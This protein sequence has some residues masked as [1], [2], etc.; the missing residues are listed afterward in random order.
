MGGAYPAAVADLQAGGL[1]YV[2]AN[3]RDKWPLKAGWLKR[4]ASPEEVAAARSE[5]YLLLGHVPYRAGLLVVDIDTDRGKPVWWWR[6]AVE[7]SLGP[8]LFE[9]RTGSG[10]LHL[11]YRCD[12]PV[13][14]RSWAGGE[15]RCAKGHAVLWDEDAVLAALE[16]LSEADPVDLSRW[17]I[18]RVAVRGSAPVHAALDQTARARSALRYLIC[19]ELDYDEWL[20]VGMG[21]HHGEH[22]GCVDD[23]RELWREWSATDPAR[24]KVG[25]C[26]A[27]WRGFDPDGGITLGTL[28]W[29]AKRHGW[30]VRRGPRL[31][32]PK[33]D[34]WDHPHLNRRQ[35]E[36]H[37]ILSAIAK[38]GKGGRLTVSVLQQTLADHHGCSRK[39][40]TRDV[41]HLQRCGYLRRV[42]RKTIREADGG[43]VV[44][45]YR[46]TDPDRERWLEHAREKAQP[47]EGQGPVAYMAGGVWDIL[48]PIPG[49][50]RGLPVLRRRADPAA[51]P[52]E[53]P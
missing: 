46:P 3:A 51:R 8:P 11:Y 2:V 12:R 5:P 22:Y 6:E 10:G 43:F 1:H 28:F 24:Y 14:N 48:P 23:G 39:T 34:E 37:S 32:K 45:V 15:I 35:C 26:A 30:K 17:P 47:A 49:V 38:P 42:G 40:V 44:P 20:Y 27:K 4:P 18:N 13:G 41:A 33:A 21:L 31:S 52:E 7:E 9:V 25:E 36:T 19:A 29:L 50:G 53:P 16:G